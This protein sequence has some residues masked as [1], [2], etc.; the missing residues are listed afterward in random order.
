M[1]NK[2]LELILDVE[3]A[4]RRSTILTDI[5]PVFKEDL[6]DNNR[7]A[8]ISQQLKIIYS[9]QG[10]ENIIFINLDNLD[11]EELKSQIERAQK[12]ELIIRN[13]YSKVF[14]F[15]KVND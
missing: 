5:R 13:D 11:L 1:S 3:N 12:K 4:Y 14:T 9:T 6:N 10:E 15:L 2:G 8:I 7:F